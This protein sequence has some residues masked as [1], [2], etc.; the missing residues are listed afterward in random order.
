[1][2]EKQENNKKRPRDNY[3]ITN[4]NYCCKTKQTDENSKP[5]R[6]RKVS[7]RNTGLVKVS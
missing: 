6:V 1:M 4:V 3:A 5:N 2:I 7:S